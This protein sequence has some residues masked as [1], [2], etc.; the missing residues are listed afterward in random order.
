MGMLVRFVVCLY[1]SIVISCQCVNSKVGTEI[2]SQNA[3]TLDMTGFIRYGDLVTFLKT[4]A[5]ILRVPRD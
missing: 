4:K 2:W 1:V 3:V 5:F